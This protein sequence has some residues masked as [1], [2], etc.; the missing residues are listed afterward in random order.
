MEVAGAVLRDMARGA[1]VGTCEEIQAVAAELLGARIFQAD[2]T[3]DYSVVL[4]KI[5][6]ALETLARC[7][8]DGGGILIPY[9]RTRNVG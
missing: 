3:P 5:A 8:D 4:G 2:R 1:Y 6:T 7:V 9:L